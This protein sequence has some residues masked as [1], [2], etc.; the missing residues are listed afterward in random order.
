V[1]KIGETMTPRQR[2]LAALNHREPDRVPIDFGGNQTGIHKDAYRALIRHLG[3]D[4]EIEI[5]DAVQ[6]LARPS[7]AV[8]GRLRVDTRYI[9]AGAAEGFDG[10]IVSAER[11]GKQWH[12]LTDE[13]G[14]RWSMPDNTPLYMDI[15]RHPLADASIDDLADYPWPQGNDPGRF[16]GLR[17]RAQWLR[18]ETPYAVVSGISGVVYEICWYM[19]GLQQW[20][21]DMLE[22]PEF[23]EAL[24][25]WTLKFW[26]DWFDAFLTEVG[27]LV[28]V[29]T[30]GDDLA[31]Q[32]GPL[33]RP[34][35][36]RSVVKPKQKRLVQSIKHR[37]TAKIWY[38]TC[39]ACR[40]YIPD[41]LDNGIDALNPV[42]ISAVDMD[43]GALKAEFGD[44]LAF[45]GGAI[46]AQHVLP[47][48]APETVRE[49]VRRNIA[50]FAPGGGYVFSNV[51]NIQAGVRPQSVLAMYDAAY[52][53]GTADAE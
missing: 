27:D 34:D 49:H 45:W 20:F 29:I 8:L 18:D 7:E 1:S 2:V 39:G 11:N 36:Y 3:V 51:H 15:T 16:A 9:H 23:C 24:L 30:I 53:F 10:S 35:F 19:R 40:S 48:A 33:F 26:L 28:D 21:I 4:E 42:Q 47:H 31:G 25:E 38:H 50:A 14:V 46:D 52:E 17:D 6:Q 44:R 12:D 41:L 22:R 32:R 5:M 37:T 43:P 13:F